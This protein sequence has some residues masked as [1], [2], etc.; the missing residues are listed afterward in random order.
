[1]GHAIVLGAGISGL[2]AARALAW[3]FDRVT[4]VERDRLPGEA[5]PRRGVPQGRHVHALLARGGEA[6]DVLFP[7]LTGELES[8]GAPVSTLL[9]EAS[10]NLAGGELARGDIGARMVQASRPLL[11]SVVRERVAALGQVKIIEGYDATGLTAEGSRVTGVRIRARGRPSTAEDGTS[12][13]VVRGELVVD[14]LGRAGRSAAWLAELGY[15]RPSERR[16]KVDL[17]YTSRLFRMPED[18]LGSDRVLLVASVPGHPTRGLAGM[19]Q[20]GDRWLLT[21][22]G[23][24]GDHPPTDLAEFRAFARTFVPP[25][26]E[27]AL[28]R[29]EPLDDGFAYRFPDGVRRWYEKLTAL[30]DGLV[31]VGDS[32]CSFN[33]VYGQGMTVA[34]LEA[35][36]LERC[37]REGGQEELPRRYYRAAAKVLDTPWRFAA[38][39][40]LTLP[41]AEGKRARSARLASGYM[42][43]L[44]RVAHHDP[45]VAA[46]LLR[47]TMLLDPPSALFAPR[48]AARVLRGPEAAARG[49]RRR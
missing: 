7:G 43:R 30:P 36:A 31:A 22:S 9:T 20:E 4:V 24:Q 1:M 28:S 38:E 45:V 29:A 15:A 25:R 19:L 48:M 26:V 40:D 33:P 47:V 5:V 13:E 32:V 12:G 3:H 41:G 46:G 10:Y 39:A 35:Q 11:E 34:V 37:L 23:V 44:R 16:V 21:L 6:I 2:L 49:R 27:A 18:A 14:A 8:L 17:G 42:L